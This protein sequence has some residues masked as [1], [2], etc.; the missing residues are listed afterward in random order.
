MD[1]L[2]LFERVKALWPESLDLAYDISHRQDGDGIRALNEAYW[3]LDERLIDEG[4]EWMGLAAW[5]FHQSL[6]DLAEKCISEG[7][8][9]LRPAGITFH[10][11]DANM[12]A[13]LADDEWADFRAEYEASLHQS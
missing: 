3:P 12:R 6:W 2:A 1:K 4:D 13:N 11:F 8:E 9:T 10:A 7:D 5:A